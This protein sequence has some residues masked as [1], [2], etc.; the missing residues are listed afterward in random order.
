MKL[1][2]YSK[3]AER[4]DQNPFRISEVQYDKDIKEYID[5]I[6]K[7]FYNILDLACGTGLYLDKQ[8]EAFK[9]RGISW[10]GLDA[11]EE[12]LKKAKEK[13][14]EVNFIQ[15][16]AEDMPYKSDTFDF[17]SNNYAFHHFT[18]KDHALDEI[19]RILVKDGIYKLH[20]I[21]IHDM[22]QWWV[23]HYFPSA[24]E[25]DVKRYWDKNLIFKEL[26]ERGFEVNLKINYRMEEIKVTDYLVYA[27]NR[28]ISVLTL[29]SDDEYKEGLEKMKLD[30]ENNPN[31][32]IVNDFAEMF[33]IAKKV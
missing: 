26:K 5:N 10:Y 28:D 16:F 9:D 25:E 1:T 30:V 3:I 12:M 2:N 7:P 31:K 27:E 18:K 33:S 8:L 32:T 19:H 15:G 11:S 13:V 24:Y 4:Y 6:E 29:I 20:N 14:T 21:S 22:P 23:Y 17:I